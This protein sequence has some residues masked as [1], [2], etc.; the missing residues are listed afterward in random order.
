[1]SSIEWPSVDTNGVSFPAIVSSADLFEGEL[2]GDEL[3]DIY[4]SAV[5]NGSDPSAMDN[6]M[7]FCVFHLNT[8]GHFVCFLTNIWYLS[9][10][11]LNSL[12]PVETKH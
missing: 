4:H 10:T 12:L 7:V 11:F 2:F 9:Q 1:M 8:M 6:G 5:D 3:I